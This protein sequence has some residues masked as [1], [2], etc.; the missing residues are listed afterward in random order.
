M[1]SGKKGKGRERWAAGKGKGKDKGRPAAPSKGRKTGNGGGK[2]FFG[3]G[4]DPAVGRAT[5]IKPGEVKNPHGRSGK[6]KPFTDAILEVLVENPELAKKMVRELFASGEAKA[7][8]VM[9]DR[10]EGKPAQQLKISG[11]AKAPLVVKNVADARNRFVEL[12]QRARSRAAEAGGVGGGA[13]AAGGDG[14]AGS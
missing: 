11:D 14:A 9:A 3:Q 8:A 1:A 13:A 4:I 12:L 2:K 7:F 10:V 6:L 5:Q